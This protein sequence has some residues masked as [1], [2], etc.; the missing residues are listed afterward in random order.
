VHQEK[1]RISQVERAA[2][3]GGAKFVDVARKHLHVAQ[4]ERRH[5][6]PGPLDGRLAEVDAN[7]PAV[8]AHHL[9]HDGER[10]DRAAAAL[11]GMPAFLHADPAEGRPGHLLGGLSDAQEPPKILIAAVEDVAPDPLGDR[12]GHGQPPLPSRARADLLYRTCVLLEE[13]AAHWADTPPADSAGL[14]NPLVGTRLGPSRVKPPLPPGRNS[15]TVLTTSVTRQDH[16]AI[17]VPLAGVTAGQ[18][19]SLRTVTG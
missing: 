7:H 1:P 6:R 10:A 14:G 19:G 11:N 12:F 3:G 13:H 16:R 2:H 5:D 15:W 9:R 4:L 17:N 18:P 8:R